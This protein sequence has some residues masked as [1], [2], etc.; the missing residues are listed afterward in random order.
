MVNDAARD[1]YPD[2]AAMTGLVKGWRRRIPYI[3]R[4]GRRH[5]VL[6]GCVVLLSAFVMLVAL[7][8]ATQEAAEHRKHATELHAHSFNVLL[9]I[10]E[11]DSF[12][13]TALRSERAYLITRDESFLGPYEAARLEAPNLLSKLRALTQDNPR[14]QDSLALL[15]SRMTEFFQL[16]DVA[17][18]TAR[19]GNLDQA[20]QFDR[21]SRSS[22]RAVLIFDIVEQIKGEEKRVLEERVAHERQ[23]NSRSQSIRYA[24]IGFGFAVLL[25]ACGVGL[26]ALDGN[27]Q[28]LDANQELSRIA[29]TDALTG[30]PNRRSFLEELGKV[31]ARA[32]RSGG[33]FSLA[34]FD[35]D[36]FKV[37][38]DTYGHPAGD[39]VLQEIARIIRSSIREGDV[40]ARLGGEEFVLLMPDTA[41]E[42]AGFV[43]ERLRLAVEAHRFVLPN[44]ASIPVTISAG[45]AQAESG[46]S[47]MALA[48]RADT[49]LYAAKNNGRNRVRLA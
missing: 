24:M 11:L 18:G 38:N 35:I 2:G 22:D 19:S 1:G 33:P 49:A 14:Q 21:S 43:C 46:E 13:N 12:L 10:S 30:L 44:G 40:A 45:A 4:R 41:L 25:L 3:F 6:S 5:V 39:A 8:N 47:E 16:L 20:F 15:D 27:V 7:A 31:S 48:S 23:A 32:K 9:T 37:V 36:F 26:V 17:V 28:A 29:T 34:V 42:A